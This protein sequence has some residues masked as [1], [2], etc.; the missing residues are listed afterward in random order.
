MEKWINEYIEGL[1]SAE[2]HLQVML[3]I[4]LL[5]YLL[6]KIHASY[7]HLRYIH[8]TATSRIASAA[9][10]YVELRGW[11]EF[12]P[13]SVTLS[14]FSQQRCL[15]YQCSVEKR[16]KMK[17]HS[18]WETESNEVSDE[19]FVLKDDT[20]ECVIIPDGAHVIESH[21]R[22][23][24]GSSVQARFQPAVTSGRLGSLVGFGEY[25]FT[26]KM[27]KVA[28]SL[29]ATGFFE[30]QQKSIQPQALKQ[31]VHNLVQTWKSSPSRYLA[32]FDRDKDGKITRQEWKQIY[33]HAERKIMQQQ[34]HTVHHTLRRPAQENQPFIISARPEWE[35]VNKKRQSI[36]IY[37]VVFFFLLYILLTA[38]TAP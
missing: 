37:L 31:Q 15:W 13:G 24:Y 35:L 2:Y 30:T 5:C 9:Q 6:Y 20:G 18:D 12:L 26:E 19:L 4:I 14:P 32:P 16:Q 25:R 33:L 10:G 34:Q 22:T 29:Y 7:H 21:K 28:D 17:Q 38:I 3:L 27:I 8:D 1:S 23:W 11:G 36:A